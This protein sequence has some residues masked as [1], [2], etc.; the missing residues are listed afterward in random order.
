MAKLN[1]G[2]SL[3]ACGV[4]D[5][6]VCAVDE[7]SKA[8]QIGE[9]KPYV[10]L[11]SQRD[12][13]ARPVAS[14]GVEQSTNTSALKMRNDKTELGYGD[15]LLFLGTR[16]EDVSTGNDRILVDGQVSTTI[17]CNLCSFILLVATYILLYYITIS[18][19]PSF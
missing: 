15:L 19:K 17:S 18:C 12:K 2:A 6:I 1:P 14:K 7:G 9:L 11:T 4:T 16:R 10:E 13:A 5:L 3:N 8:S